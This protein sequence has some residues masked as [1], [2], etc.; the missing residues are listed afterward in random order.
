MIN[1]FDI[2]GYDDP[3][4]ASLAIQKAVEMIEDAD[5]DLTEGPHGEIEIPWIPRPYRFK[6][7]IVMTKPIRFVMRGHGHC[8]HSGA[9]FTIKSLPNDNKGWHVELRGVYRGFPEYTQKNPRL[10]EINEEG[11]SL[12]RFENAEDS[13]FFVG[14]NVQGFTKAHIEGA[15]HIKGNQVQGNTIEYGVSANNGATLL[16]RSLSSEHAAFQV[17]GVIGRSTH[18]N[19]INLAIDIPLEGQSFSNSNNNTFAGRRMDLAFEPTMGGLGIDCY[20][21]YNDFDFPFCEG[22]AIWREGSFYNWMK[23]LNN[24]ESGFNWFDE[25]HNNIGVNMPQDI[26][27]PAYVP[28]VSG[29]WFRNTYGVPLGVSPIGNYP[30]GSEIRVDHRNP[31]GSPFEFQKKTFNGSAADNDSLYTPMMPNAQ[32]KIEVS[33]GASMPGLRLVQ[34]A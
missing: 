5:T 28:I 19:A 25:G 18:R 29:E 8:I 2:P 32:I 4:K 13:Y 34:A 9:L 17:N 30:P 12:I 14:D 31:D 21:N 10:P 16:A 3:D 22:M 27:F 20:G 1:P 33:G 23:P 11:T 6:D 24:R 15:C 26:T 7:P